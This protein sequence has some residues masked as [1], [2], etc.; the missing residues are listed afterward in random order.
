M[1]RPSRRHNKGPDTAVYCNNMHC[2]SHGRQRSKRQAMSIRAG[3]NFKFQ[4][5]PKLSNVKKHLKTL[6]LMLTFIYE[7]V[8]KFSSYYFIEWYIWT[9]VKRFYHQ[10][11]I[12]FE[13]TSVEVTATFPPLSR[14]RRR[15]MYI[16]IHCQWA[17]NIM[18]LESWYFVHIKAK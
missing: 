8:V 10:I 3:L 11:Y 4:I 6:F 9:I 14:P 18:S 5:I 1:L 16:G 2:M 13:R 17:I 15:L 7:S 12:S